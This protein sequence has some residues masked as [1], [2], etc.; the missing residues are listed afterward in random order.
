[1]LQT[2]IEPLNL[3][4][5]IKRSLRDIWCAAS[6]ADITHS[7]PHCRPIIDP[8]FDFVDCLAMYESAKQ[9]NRKSE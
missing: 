6:R 3:S 7:I 5:K 1:M 2:D 9:R 8:I 4:A